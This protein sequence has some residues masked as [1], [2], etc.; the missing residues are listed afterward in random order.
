MHETDWQIPIEPMS[1]EQEELYEDTPAYLLPNCQ[2]AISHG[3][4]LIDF[5]CSPLWVGHY[6]SLGL[7]KDFPPEFY[8][9]PQPVDRFDIEQITSLATAVEDLEVDVEDLQKKL[10][11][12]IKAAKRR[13]KEMVDAI[14]PKR[15][16]PADGK[17]G[18][19][20]L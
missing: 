11:W 12:L 13:A 6:A 10:R 17:G 15:A 2:R 9:E 7:T 5:P 4:D 3:A 1:S 18:F 8:Q 16:A 14:H 19:Q 20:K